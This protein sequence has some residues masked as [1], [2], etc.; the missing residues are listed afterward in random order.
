MLGAN[1]FI[2]MQFLAQIW[3][4]LGSVPCRLGSPRSATAFEVLCQ[5]NAF[6]GKDITHMSNSELKKLRNAIPKKF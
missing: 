3:P 6:I 2:F 1:S 4:L 5:K